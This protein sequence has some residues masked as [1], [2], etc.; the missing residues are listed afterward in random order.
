V[1]GLKLLL[2]ADLDA[3]AAD[4]AGARQHY[5]DVITLWQH[6][7]AAVQPYVQ[8]ARTGLARLGHHS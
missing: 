8:R 7:D 4:S 6:G 1:L 3:A 2:L 5:A